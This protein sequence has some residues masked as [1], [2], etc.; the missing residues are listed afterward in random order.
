LA[1]EQPVEEQFMQM[2]LTNT[3]GDTYYA[4][5]KELVAE[6]EKTHAAMLA[7]D[8]SFVAKALPYARNRGFMRTQPIYGLVRMSADP[9]A[10]PYFEATFNEVIKTP[11]DLG[12][13]FTILHAQ[14]KGEG[15]RRVKR[16]AGNWLMKNLSPYWAVK[17]GATKQGGYS[18]R[19]LFCTLHPKGP[20]SVLVD[21]LFGRAAEGLPEAVQAFERLKRATTDAEKVSAIEAGRLPHEVASSF[22]GKSADVWTAIVK[23]MPVFAMLR[24]LA[25][26]ERHGVMPAV[27]DH[28]VAT[29]SNKEVIAKSKILPFRFVEAMKHVSDAKVQ[30]ALRDALDHSFAGVPDIEGRTS[31]FLDISGSMG[32]MIQ[33]ASVFAISAMKK[34]NGNGRLLLFDTEVSEVK[35]SMRDSTLTQANQIRVRGGTDHSAPM[36]LI[37]NEK[38]KYDNILVITDEQ[39]NTGGPFVDVLQEYRKHV[40]GRAKCFV[41]NVAP[42]HGALSGQMVPHDSKGLNFFVYGWSDQ[43]L[44]FIAMASQGWSSFVEA[45]RTG[46]KPALLD[47]ID[48]A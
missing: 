32:A 24:N 44:S 15:G 21:Y 38:D 12:D 47:E 1:F 33:S 48:D 19:D 20:K 14:R 4:T 43:A 11:N 6:A 45:V 25:T 22:A 37:L 42:Y 28:V 3:F 9:A 16:V 41:L 30:D 5:Q 36:G 31:I 18:L 26:M 7:K 27:R 10:A 39:T 13:F 17:Y 34:A 23:H 46:E 2:L 8:P 40:N 35:V 29:L